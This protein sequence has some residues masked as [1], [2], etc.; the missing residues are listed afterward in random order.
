MFEATPG[1]LGEEALDGVEPGTR[2]WGVVEHEAGMTI[3]PSPRFGMLVRPVIIEDDV[4]DLADR[5]L[6]LDGVQE[7]NELLMPMALHAAPDDLAVEHI[8]CGE[9]VVVPLRL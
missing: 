1:Q 6:G 7:T 9:Q 3:E 5:N 8:E 4:D 2:G